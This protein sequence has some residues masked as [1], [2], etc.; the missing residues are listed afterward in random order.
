MI[1]QSQPRS[2]PK[3]DTTVDE[4]RLRQQALGSKLRQMFNEVV[5]EP[6]P[7][8]FIEILRRGDR[9]QGDD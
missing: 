5:N 6:V 4:A 1:D 8:D 7:E 2:K 3:R 9:K